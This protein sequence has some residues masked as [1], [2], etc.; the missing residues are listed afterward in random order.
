[1]QE[2]ECKMENDNNTRKRVCFYGRVS[3]EHESQIAALENQLQW[4]DEMKKMHPEWDVL[5]KYIDRGITGTLA[6]KRPQ[7]MQMIRDA[8]DKKFDLIVTR[9]VCRFARNTVDTLS[10]CRELKQLGVEVYFVSDNIFTFSE[11][12]ELRLTIMAALAQE[13]SRKTSERVKAGQLISR[14]NGI[15]YGNGNILGYTLHRNIDENGNW[16]SKDN[17][18]VIDPEQAETVRLIYQMCLEGLGFLKISKRLTELERKNAT[19]EVSWCQSKISRIL[20]NKTYC[21]YKCYNKSTTTDAILH[22]REKNLDTDSYEYIKGDWEPII[23]E[24]DWLKV[25]EILKEKADIVVERKKQNEDVCTSLSEDIW[26]KKLKCSCGSSFRRNKWRT[27]KLS[28]EVVFG[29]QC[30][31]QVN[32]GA[33]STRRK[34]G[35][36]TD[37]YCDIR[38]VGDWKLE[39][40]AK[41]ILKELWLDRTSTIEKALELV[42]KYYKEESGDEYDKKLEKN[43]KIEIT[44]LNNRMDKLLE[45]RL[46]GEI[47]AQQFADKKEKLEQQIIQMQSQLENTSSV[48]DKIS[49]INDLL[50]QA[51]KVLEQQVDF[52]DKSTLYEVINDIVYQIVPLENSRYKWILKLTDRKYLYYTEINGRK[53]K[54]TAAG[55]REKDLPLVQTSTGCY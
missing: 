7:F 51:R 41:T 46:D 29:Y 31:N 54:A 32:N 16:E 52:S 38:M 44:K 35:L 43:I 48:E 19:G 8:K 49:D 1:M 30:Y 42:K 27:N 22:S 40:M 17:T 4:Y 28:Q 39:F 34:Q 11:D 10:Y 24:E 53:N 20:H 36:S 37:G 47:T 5:C 6:K 55:G 21:G 33:A 50:I 18:Y 13:E 25:Q 45:I 15:L 9:E 14:K 2:G 23:T 12:G 3:T 26:V